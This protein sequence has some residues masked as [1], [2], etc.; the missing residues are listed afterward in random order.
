VLAVA[1]L[2]AALGLDG[3]VATNTTVA[4][5][6]LRS[7]PERVEAAGAGGLSGRPLK[8]RALEV[9][10]LLRERVGADLTLVAVGG[11]E[12]AQDAADRLA[13]GATLLQA[14]TAF[15]YEGALWPARLQR[16]LA[17][18]TAR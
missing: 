15:V 17:R 14:Y 8:A 2:A 7:Q 13:A 12:T 1:D 3:I 5:A 10:T 9:L 18:S 16:D 11:I 4:R 6:G